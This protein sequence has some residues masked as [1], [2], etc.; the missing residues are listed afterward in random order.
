MLRASL[1]CLTVFASSAFALDKWIEDARPFVKTLTRSIDIYTWE[2][3]VSWINLTGEAGGFLDQEARKY[4]DAIQP[5]S[6]EGPNGVYFATDP[7]VSRE[8]GSNQ[9][10]PVGYVD[11]GDWS[12]IRVRLPQGTPFLDARRG[13]VALPLSIQQKLIQKGCSLNYMT[14]ES[15]FNVRSQATKSQCWSVYTELTQTL[16][17]AMIAKSFYAFAPS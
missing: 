15:L 12:L 11:T 14:M 5:L 17:I 7:F 8:W 13:G 10:N 9:I 1:I 6:F 4:S 16:G 2:P 3:R